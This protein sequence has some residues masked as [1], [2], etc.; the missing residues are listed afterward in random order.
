MNAQIQLQG[1]IN[2]HDEAL[3]NNNTK[4]AFHAKNLI[5]RIKDKALL[6]NIKNLD[7]LCFDYFG[8]VLKNIKTN[9]T[10][11]LPAGDVIGWYFRKERPMRFIRTPKDNFIIE[12]LEKDSKRLEPT[13]KEI[14]EICV[15]YRYN[16]YEIKS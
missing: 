12:I 7:F 4:M 3:N 5:T 8:I 11:C 2:I 10:Y 1:L 16:L 6:D 14:N 9:K 15:E 13:P